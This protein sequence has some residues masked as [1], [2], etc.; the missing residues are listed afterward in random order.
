MGEEDAEIAGRWL[1]KI[2]RSMDQIAVQQSSEW[3][4]LLSYYRTEPRHG[5]ILLKRDGLLRRLDGG[6]SGQSLKTSIIPDSIER[7]KNRSSW[8][9]HREIWQYWNMRDGFKT[10]LCLLLF[11]Y[12]LSSIGSRDSEMDSDRS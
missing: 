3:I 8:L 2:E 5:G 9:L 7:S 6:I 4:V 1:R 12:R 10:S 11:I